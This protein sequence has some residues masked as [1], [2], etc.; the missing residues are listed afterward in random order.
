MFPMIRY[1]EIFSIFLYSDSKKPHLSIP[2]SI[3]IWSI[4]VVVMVIF[5]I[6]YTTLGKLPEYSNNNNNKCQRFDSI[7][8]GN[9]RIFNQFNSGNSSINGNIT[10]FL[11]M[12]CYQ[13]SLGISVTKLP[14]STSTRYLL[15]VYIDTLR[16]KQLV[17]FTFFSLLYCYFCWKSVH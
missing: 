10:S 7:T 15:H 3:E 12:Q 17:Q 11:L 9:K 16:C 5:S 1:C 14:R 8:S 13:M 6:F 4:I 2:T